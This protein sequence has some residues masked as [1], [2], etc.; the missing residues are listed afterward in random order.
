L[1]YP[2][3]LVLLHAWNSYRPAATDPYLAR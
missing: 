3:R 1:H 2:L